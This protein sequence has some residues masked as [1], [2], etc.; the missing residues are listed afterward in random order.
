MSSE[1]LGNQRAFTP[2][3]VSHVYTQSLAGSPDDIMPL[4]TPLGEKA[5]CR[6]WDPVILFQAPEPGDGTVFAV[7]H[8]GEPDTIWLLESFDAA[9]RRVRYLHVTPG[10][11]VTEIDIALRGAAGAPD[12]TEAVV[13]YTYTGFS[14][15]GN[16]LVGAMT[17]EHYRRFMIDWEGEL[18]DYLE[19]RPPR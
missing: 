18:N 16:A 6:G 10:S 19:R 14:E 2:R 4:L 8:P 9:G 3:Q 13:R 12:R 7:R 5:W 15:R 1:V 17:A 11:D